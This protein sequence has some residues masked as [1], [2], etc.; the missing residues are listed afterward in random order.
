MKEV[1][2]KINGKD[3]VATEG[4]TIL[5]AARKAGFRIPTL[6]YHD[7]LTPHG[8][9]RLCVVEVKGS[10]RLLTSCTTP[11][12]DGM[13]VY[14][15]TDR[16]KEARKF[17]MNLIMTER[18]HFC[19]FCEKSGKYEDTDC[20]LQKR[21]YEVQIEHFPFPVYVD[22]YP[23]DTS[24]PVMVTDHNRCIL[25][26]RCVR[27]CSEIVAN[28]TLDFSFRGS[29]A[30][31]AVDTGLSKGK[32]SC[33]SCGA[34][35]QVCPAGAIFSKFGGYKS[36]RSLCERIETFCP[37]CG[38]GCETTNYVRYNNI[39]EIEG[40]G[41]VKGSLDGGQLCEKG[42]YGP[43]MESR[44]RI[45]TP[46]LRDSKG[47]FV[48]AT[49]EEALNR[50]V[51]LLKAYSPDQ[52]AFRTSSFLPAE[53]LAY[54]KEFASRIGVKDIDTFDGNVYRNLSS[55][56]L[57]KGTYED[58]L[59]ADLILLIGGDIVK[60]H[61]VVGSYIRRAVR[62]R[63]AELVV[64][65]SIE[66]KIDRWA[67]EVRRVA[68]GSEGSL[69]NDYKNKIKSMSN[70][71]IV[72][73][74]ASLLSNKEAIE[75][76]LKL[77][78]ELNVKVMIL[79]PTGNSLAAWELGISPDLADSAGKSKKLLFLFL[80]DI[81]SSYS[82]AS[83]AEKGYETIVLHSAY[84][85][86]IMKLSDVV[87]PG[88]SWLENEGTYKVMDGKA[89]RFSPILKAEKGVKSPRELLSDLADAMRLGSISIDDIVRKL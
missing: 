59:N 2:L 16:V 31:I 68:E 85:D 23:V 62:N 28:S 1:K 48:E 40:N 76:W 38:I 63:G 17:V 14:T 18:N 10:P 39:V 24:S 36:R 60:E 55:F 5:E 79:T 75:P 27:V 8:G 13:E 57:S 74:G 11:V 3:V 46:L 35:M 77:A 83:I 21:A 34:C 64:I 67:K 15:D 22:K 73:E 43:L 54:I 86:A 49:Y 19:M 44:N 53:D 42:R 56:K 30:L 32:S 45:S 47:R 72:L 58:V 61:S 81:D 65:S 20:E 69:A 52:I 26:G 88:K 4:M 80:G 12:A 33:I 7:G 9:C 41:L 37:I 78:E 66:S 51:Q 71:I 29:K 50:V 6:C 87:I 89:R 84:I 82:P 25:C 70:S